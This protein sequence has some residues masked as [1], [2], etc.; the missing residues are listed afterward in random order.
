MSSESLVNPIANWHAQAQDC[1]QKGAYAEAA[2]LY[3]QAI[4]AAP[5]ERSLYWH[6]GLLLLLQGQEAEAQ[7][8]WL[9]VLAEAEVEQLEEWTAEL[10]Q[11]LETEAERQREQGDP[12]IAWAIRQH[13]REIVPDQIDN[14]LH[15]IQISARLEQLTGD[16]L[17]SLEV[18]AALQSS[19]VEVNAD[20]LLSV[21]DD[22]LAAIPP[23][24]IVVDFTEACLPRI[25]YSNALR[26]VLLNHAIKIAYSL[27]CPLLSAHLLEA[28]RHFDP[29]NIEM[30]GH[31]AIFYQNAREFDKGIEI[32]QTHYSLAD[33][34]VEKVFSSNLLLRGLMAAGGRWDDSLQLMESHRT[35]LSTLIEENPAELNSAN[36]I[37]LFNAPF[38]FPYFRDDLRQ[39]R[40]VQNLVMQLCQTNIE[41]Y[42][43]DRITRYQKPRSTIAAPLLTKRLKVGYL[44]H[45]MGQHSVG[46]LARWLIQHHDRQQVDLHGYFVTERRGDAL[47]EWY[48]NQLEHTCQ[49][50]VDCRDNA[51][52]LADRIYEDD[53]DI[54]IDLDSIT[55]DVTCEIMSLKPAPVQATWLGWDAPGISAINYVIA[56]PYVL[57]NWA[58]DYYPETIWR[59]PHSY[60]AVDGFEVEVPTLR[61]DDLNIPTDA[62]IYLTSQKGYKRHRDT[63]ILQMQIIKNVPNSYFL[64][65]GFADEKSIQ[66]FFYQLAEEEGI[67]GD[68]LRFLPNAPSEATHRANL[69]IAD[70]VLDTF[71]YNGATTTLETLWMGVP[72]VTR[73]GEQFAARNSYTM[74]KNVGVEEGIAWTD[75]EYIEWGVRFG[76]DAALRQSVHW[77]LLQSRQTAPLWNAKQFTREMEEAYYKMAKIRA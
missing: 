44:S 65:K 8:T 46:W 30:L 71:P 13:I 55:L 73:V 37:R 59:L 27:R 51:L 35:L 24:G 6:L 36:T 50:G 40:T 53:L 29:D 52:D 1:W 64:I 20:F 47:Q 63:A 31:L 32:A 68:R 11:V 69:A 9:L 16:E 7:T 21:L 28:Y 43:K 22:V 61:R 23:D 39:N 3:S 15:L 49:M 19:P 67:E 42:A 12:A 62:I 76:T 25:P 4:A 75:A 58:Q 2:A 10:V 38:F 45:C 66:D 54:L 14:L 77:K 70:V 41:Q 72:L 74:L 60:I 56:D 17:A 18:I 34:I 48:L 57:P 5:Q 26:I 33:S